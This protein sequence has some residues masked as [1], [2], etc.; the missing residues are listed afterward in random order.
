MTQPPEPPDDQPPALPEYR[1]EPPWGASPGAQQYSPYPM[2]GTYPAQAYYPPQMGPA[3]Q[4]PPPPLVRPTSGMAVAG[5]VCALLW[6]CGVLSLLG[7]ILSTIAMRETKTGLKG[8]HGFAVAEAII[9]GL[10]SLGI[11][12]WVIASISS[13]LNGGS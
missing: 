13:S 2:P 7:L 9:G 12:F 11:V 8:G 10:G 4:Y 3:H 1:Q 6:G 5:F